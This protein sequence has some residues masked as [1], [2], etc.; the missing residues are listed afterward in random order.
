MTKY[1]RINHCNLNNLPEFQRFQKANP[2]KIL[3]ERQT[4][5]MF[6]RAIHWLAILDILWPN[7]EHR[8]Y[9]SVEIAHIVENDPDNTIMPPSFYTQ[10]AETLAMFWEIKLQD[11]YPNGNWI[12][13]I[14]DDPEITVDVTIHSR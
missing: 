10:I 7:F 9:Y 1:P 4:I 13:D 6:G 14:G 11:L 5:I 8:D 3:D 2:G 12:I